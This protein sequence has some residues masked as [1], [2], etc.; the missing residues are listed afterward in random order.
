[1]E[2]GVAGGGTSALS[3]NFL[4]QI[5]SQCEYIGVDTFSGFTE[6][7]FTADVERGND[8]QKFSAFSAN[9]MGI[10]KKVLKIHGAQE[11]KLIQGDISKVDASAMPERI[12]ACLLDVDL[13]VPI[14][15]GLKLVWPLLEDGGVIVVVI[16]TKTT[17]V[18]GKPWQAIGNFAARWDWMSISFVV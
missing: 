16:V 2:I 3:F 15:D 4:R 12:S 10:V 14:Y 17:R 8:P 11:V 18:T 13:F 6:E 5:A 7:Q 1:M 9:S